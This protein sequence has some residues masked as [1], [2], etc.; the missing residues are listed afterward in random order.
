MCIYTCV[1]VHINVRMCVCACILVCVYICVCVCAHECMVLRLNTI[2]HEKKIVE[3]KIKVEEQNNY[4]RKCWCPRVFKKDVVVQGRD[5][6]W[7]FGT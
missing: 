4:F 2:G 7:A 1:H 6:R 5:V 3:R